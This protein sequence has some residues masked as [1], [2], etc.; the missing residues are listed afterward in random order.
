[1]PSLDGTGGAD[2][3]A[4]AAIN[5]GSGIDDSLVGHADSTDGAGVNAG[6]ASNA[7]AGNGMSHGDT[8]YLRA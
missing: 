7:F 3:F 6:A 1:M 5:A 2:A 8:P 4:S